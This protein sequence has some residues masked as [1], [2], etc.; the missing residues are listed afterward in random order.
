MMLL[1]PHHQGPVRSLR[2]SV[3]P[4]GDARSL[5]R[6]DATVPEAQDIDG[7]E[8]SDAAPL[9]RCDTTNPVALTVF[10]GTRTLKC[11]SVACVNL[12][13]TVP[14]AECGAAI[15]AAT[16]RWSGGAGLNRPSAW[17]RPWP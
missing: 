15:A 5:T 8:P 7:G 12:L 9:G 2:E 10:R 17:G 14:G 16:L 13:V 6:A 4:D 1:H 3:V 11:L